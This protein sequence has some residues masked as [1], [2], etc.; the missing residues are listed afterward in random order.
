MLNPTS[1]SASNLLHV[2]II[3]GVGAPHKPS[4]TDGKMSKI[5][6]SS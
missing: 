1:P 3:E 2:N 6:W 4:I 5:K